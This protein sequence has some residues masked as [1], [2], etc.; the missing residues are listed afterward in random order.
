M[1]QNDFFVAI[2]F[3]FEAASEAGHSLNRIERWMVDA[4]DE[5]TSEQEENDE[6][7]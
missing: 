3:V 7:A 5:Y 1:T 6:T 4:F 2:Q